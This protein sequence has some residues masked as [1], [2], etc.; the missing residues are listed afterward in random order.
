MAEG[1]RQ[2][3]GATHALAITGIAGPD[4]GTPDKPVGTVYIA[5]ASADRPTHVRRFQFTGT[6]DIVRDRSAKAALAMLL[7][8]LR[9]QE[10][11]R[12][13]WQKTNGESVK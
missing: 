6:R 10:D 12:M 2:R 4:G 5:L 3:A 13:L 1:A 9:G 7:W 11:F 8:R